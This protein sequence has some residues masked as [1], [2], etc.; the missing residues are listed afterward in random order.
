MLAKYLQG[1]IADLKLK[2]EAQLIGD[3]DSDEELVAEDYSWIGKPQ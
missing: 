1:M 3:S 2:N